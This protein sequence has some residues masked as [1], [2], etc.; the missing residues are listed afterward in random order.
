MNE[1]T[2]NRGGLPLVVKSPFTVLKEYTLENAIWNLKYIMSE[3]KRMIVKT[4]SF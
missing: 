2:S 1:G 4:G 3:E